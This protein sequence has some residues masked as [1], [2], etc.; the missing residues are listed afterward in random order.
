MDPLH[1]EPHPNDA[2]DLGALRVDPAAGEIRGPA[3]RE[4]LDPKVM[5]V[6]R[7]LNEQRGTLVPREVLFARVWPDRIVTDDV[8]SRCIYQLRRQLAAAAGA[9]GRE[10]IETLPKRGYR[11][12]AEPTCPEPIPERPATRADS[13]RRGEC[14]SILAKLDQSWLCEARQFAA[15]VRL[16]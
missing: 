15:I 10:L 9:D 2:F 3:G 13:P 12:R 8:L 7:V 1:A 14:R 6:L 16:T 5:E 4:Q 11:L